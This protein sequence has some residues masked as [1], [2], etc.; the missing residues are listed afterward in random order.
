[1][2][3]HLGVPAHDGGQGLGRVDG[4]FDLLRDHGELLEALAHQGRHQRLLGG[5][6]PVQRADADP[7]VCGDVLHL[8]LGPVLGEK[9]AGRG[10]DPLEVALGIGSQWTLL[11]GHGPPP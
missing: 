10:E 6:P 11:G 7:C 8:R 3:D 1:V 2:L 9:G 5:E 4:P